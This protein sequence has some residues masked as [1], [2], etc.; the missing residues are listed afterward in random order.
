MQE[1]AGEE[2]DG[3]QDAQHDEHKDPQTRQWVRFGGIYSQR[4]ARIVSRVEPGFGQQMPIRHISQV[5]AVLRA[6]VQNILGLSGTD[7]ED[8]KGVLRFP[9]ICAGVAQ[10]PHVVVS[11][12]GLK[13]TTALENEEAFDVLQK[14]G[15]EIVG[16]ALRSRPWRDG[17]QV[18]GKV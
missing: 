5:P 15:I 13:Y 2:D 16:I 4:Q 18:C 9:L 1:H 14:D 11:G 3:Q 12:G 17:N 10:I 7:G 8:G 6:D